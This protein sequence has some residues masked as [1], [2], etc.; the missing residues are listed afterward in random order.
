VLPDMEAT[1][2]LRRLR[3]SDFAG[4]QPLP[5]VLH[6]R[7]LRLESMLSVPRESPA[8][9]EVKAKTICIRHASPELASR[10]V[11]IKHQSRSKG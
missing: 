2:L 5:V 4:R 7:A 10:E 11:R 3:L 8:V 9:R 1:L 6:R